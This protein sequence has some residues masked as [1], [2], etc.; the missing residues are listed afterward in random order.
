MIA[1]R[2]A[3]TSQALKQGRS[4]IGV[5]PEQRGDTGLPGGEGLPKGWWNGGTGRRVA[6][7]FFSGAQL[8]PFLGLTRENRTKPRWRWSLERRTT[9]SALPLH[10]RQSRSFAEA[11][12]VTKKRNVSRHERGVV[13]NPYACSRPSADPD[14]GLVGALHLQSQHHLLPLHLASSRHYASIGPLPARLQAAIP[15]P[16][17]TATWAGIAPAR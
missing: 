12:K 8:A 16:W 3:D 10:H 2:V 6:G 9:A 17:L 14:V 4:V 7:L 15:G 11:R 13:A 5:S 1:A